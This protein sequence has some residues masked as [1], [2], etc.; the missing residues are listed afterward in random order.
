MV[1]V[2]SLKVDPEG[3]RRAIDMTLERLIEAAAHYDNFCIQRHTHP[4]GPK[5]A[6]HVSP[7]GIDPAG[8][9][10]TA[11][12]DHI[13]RNPACPHC[14]EPSCCSFQQ[15]TVGVT[16]SNHLLAMLI[17]D[18][19]NSGTVPDFHW[20]GFQYMPYNALYGGDFY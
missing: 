10:P 19:G 11:D 8:I 4:N 7:A 2:A 13:A 18:Y 3:F 1:A 12:G 20:N 14:Q 5:G 9:A 15:Q 16:A 6:K 17:R